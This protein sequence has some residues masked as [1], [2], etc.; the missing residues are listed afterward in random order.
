M[1]KQLSTH[2]YDLIVSQQDYNDLVKSGMAWE[3]YPDLEFTWEEFVKN[4]DAAKGVVCQENL[5]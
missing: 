3:F 5:T 4:R 1:N 2:K